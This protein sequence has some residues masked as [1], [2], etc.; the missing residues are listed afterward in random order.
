MFVIKNQLKRIV[1]MRYEDH[2]THLIMQ[3]K[4][5]RRTFQNESCNNYGIIESN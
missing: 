1:E 3:D 2:P 4:R 5:C